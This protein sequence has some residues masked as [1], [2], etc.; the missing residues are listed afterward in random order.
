MSRKTWIVEEKDSAGNIT[1]R[2]EYTDHEE[3]NNMYNYR[4]TLREDTF[5]SIEPASTKL[6][7]G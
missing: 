5:V 7:L 2:Q 1:F 6:I 3:A 4:K